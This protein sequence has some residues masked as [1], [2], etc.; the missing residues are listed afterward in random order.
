MQPAKPHRTNPQPHQPSSY[1]TSQPNP[2]HDPTH[3]SHDP[4][5]LTHDPA[6]DPTHDRNHPTHDPTKPNQTRRLKPNDRNPNGSNPKAHQT[7]PSQ[8]DPKRP[9]HNLNPVSR[10]NR[11]ISQFSAQRATRQGTTHTNVIPDRPRPFDPQGHWVNLGTHA[12]C[13]CTSEHQPASHA[14]RPAHPTTAPATP[15]TPHPHL[16]HHSSVCATGHLPLP[17]K[18]THSPL[19]TPTPLAPPPHQSATGRCTTPWPPFTPNP[20]LPSVPRRERQGVREGVPRVVLVLLA[21]VILAS[22]EQNDPGGAVG[23][24]LWQ[25]GVEIVMVEMGLGPKATLG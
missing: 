16:T 1:K 17:P 3:P 21:H 2:T 18:V 11:S 6:H 14:V 10:A 15:S 9:P 4:N 23:V 12:V 5:H 8:T 24:E 22:G 25:G 20:P 7:E 13:C 19:T